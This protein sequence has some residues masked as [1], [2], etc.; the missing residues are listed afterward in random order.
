METIYC[1]IKKPERTLAISNAMLAGEPVEKVC[2]RFNIRAKT[3]LNC[4]KTVSEI[5]QHEISLTDGS[6]VI[7]LARF[8]VAGGLPAAASVALRRFETFFSTLELHCWQLTNGTE[9]IYLHDLK[10]PRE[11]DRK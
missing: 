8:V 11:D 4:K 1:G 2:E 7:P 6:M 10:H 5:Q 3:A 9:S